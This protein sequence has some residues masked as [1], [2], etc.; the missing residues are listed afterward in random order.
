MKKMAHLV[1]F[2]IF[3]VDMI[4]CQNL[5]LAHIYRIFVQKTHFLE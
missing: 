4:S 1:M 3:Y 2:V 5:N